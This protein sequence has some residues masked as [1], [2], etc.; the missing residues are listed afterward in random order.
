MK[1][2]YCI[3]HVGPPNSTPHATAALAAAEAERLA[4]Q[5]PGDTFEVLQCLAITRTSAPSTFW[6]DDC[7]PE[8]AA[9]EWAFDWSKVPEGRV[10]GGDANKQWHHYWSAPWQQG[11]QWIVG[12]DTD[13]T[14]FVRFDHPPFPGD[15]KDSLQIRPAKATP[16]PPEPGYIEITDPEEIIR[17]GDEAQSANGVW[18]EAKPFVGGKAGLWLFWGRLRRPDP[19]R[20]VVPIPEEYLP[21]PP[22]PEGKTQWVGRGRGTN[23]DKPMKDREVRFYDDDTD[24]SKEWERTVS[25]SLDYFHIEAI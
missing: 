17:E 3:R 20:R 9:P 23:D 10:H 2:Y 7:G 5:H 15:W 25:L 6:F 24:G 18:G 16:P 19:T 1:P 21:L 13:D 11:S 8:P 14:R 12:C 4:A 22:L